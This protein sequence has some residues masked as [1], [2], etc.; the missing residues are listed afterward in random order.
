MNERPKKTLFFLFSW[1]TRSVSMRLQAKTNQMRLF[2]LGPGQPLISRPLMA[3][4]CCACMSITAWGRPEAYVWGGGGSQAALSWNSA[5]RDSVQDK[6]LTAALWIR[7][8]LPNMP[9]TPLPLK[10][11]IPSGLSVVNSPISQDFI[12][13]AK[14]DWEAPCGAAKPFNGIIV[15]RVPLGLY[16]DMP[17]CATKGKNWSKYDKA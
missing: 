10:D 6:V 17:H 8:F 16:F 1:K 14:T 13:M 2:V 9:N 12:L 15:Q 4:S 3:S 7:T 5:R 11:M